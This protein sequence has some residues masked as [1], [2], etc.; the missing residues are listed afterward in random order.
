M[1]KYLILLGLGVLAYAFKD[2]I[3]GTTDASD[4]SAGT[5]ENTT[6]YNGNIAISSDNGNWF[7]IDNSKRWFP[8]N[9]EAI[10]DYVTAHP[11][12][13]QLTLTESQMA[14]YPISGSIQPGLQ[15]VA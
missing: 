2:K 7:I 5:D 10:T 6:D 13:K 15:F 9:Q 3:F 4:E 1:K 8:S 12:A 11:T 14:I